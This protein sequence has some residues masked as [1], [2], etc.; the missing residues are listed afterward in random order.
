L[1][2]TYADEIEPNNHN[3]NEEK[4]FWVHRAVKSLGGAISVI[5]F[6][7]VLMI[8]MSYNLEFRVGVFWIC[9]STAA[10]WA[11]LHISLTWKIEKKKEEFKN[12]TE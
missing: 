6:A 9:I 11:I 4:A 1:I 3:V 5:L 2:D 7:S 10:I 12:K 8:L